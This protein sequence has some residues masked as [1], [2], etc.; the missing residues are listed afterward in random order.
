M[1]RHGYYAC[2]SYTDKLVGDVLGELKR[3]GLADNTIVVVWGDHGWH[4]GEHNFWGKHNTMHLATRV[5]LIVKVPQKKA[6]KTESLVETSDLFPTLCGL[7]GI[8]VPKTVQGRSFEALLDYPDKP[9]R[10]VVYTRFK[11]G[12]A[13]VTDRY[14]YTSYIKAKTEM[15]YDL[16]ND[17]D[18]NRNVAGNPENAKI[19]ADMKAR[20]AERM[21][22]AENAD[23][24]GP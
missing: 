3:L 12:D 4:L 19:V 6:G 21:H 13:V 18:E 24:A 9:F 2:V 16:K 22:E 17:P 20:L 11:H 10:E 14:S 15:L 8:T 23:V 1:M 5:P 7:A